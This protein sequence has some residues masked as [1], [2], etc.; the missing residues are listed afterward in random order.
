[1]SKED[2]QTLDEPRQIQPYTISRRQTVRICKIETNH[3][4]GLQLFFRPWWAW[5]LNLS[6]ILKFKKKLFILTQGKTNSCYS[7][8]V[9][10]IVECFE[11]GEM[12]FWGYVFGIQVFECLVFF[13]AFL[14]LGLYPCV[15]FF[16]G[17]T[18]IQIFHFW[19]CI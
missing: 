18:L 7:S 13:C 11:L 12:S 8:C 1:M 6:K 14:Y 10:E 19:G 2:H 17:L 3:S 9:T 4:R 16:F 5:W 15:Y